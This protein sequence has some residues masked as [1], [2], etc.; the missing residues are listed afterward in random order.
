M[1]DKIKRNAI[2]DNAVTD[3]KI[4]AG[5]VDN[6]AIDKTVI[7]GLTETTSVADGD[8][9]IISDTSASGILKKVTKVRA[10][11]L[12]FPTYTQRASSRATPT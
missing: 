3:P 7:T 12:D 6:N 4:S 10:T 5:A 2:E 11:G 1:P 9:L 8:H